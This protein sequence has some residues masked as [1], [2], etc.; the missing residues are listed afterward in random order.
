MALLNYIGGT[1]RLRK[2]DDAIDSDHAGFSTMEVIGRASP[3]LNPTRASPAS[4][5]RTVIR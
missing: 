4:R 3:A 2:Q 5:S 1:D